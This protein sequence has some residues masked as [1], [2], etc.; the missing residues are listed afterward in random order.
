MTNIIK[1]LFQKSLRK[2]ATIQCFLFIL[3]LFF[4]FIS[5][6]FR[7]IGIDLTMSAFH[8]DWYY[9]FQKKY[10]ASFKLGKHKKL[11][12]A[13]KSMYHKG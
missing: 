3:H 12:V 10:A 7:K 1:P 4:T 2:T 5:A 13:P 6:F 8:T 11:R 9:N